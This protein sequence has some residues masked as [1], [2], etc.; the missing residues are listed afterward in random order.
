MKDEREARGQLARTWLPVAGM[1]VLLGILVWLNE[2]LDLPYLLLGMPRTRVNWSEALLETML[3]IAVGSLAMLR[4]IRDITK[5]QRVERALRESEERYRTMI[6]NAN[7][8]IWVL[9]TRGDFTII[10]RQA[11]IVSGQK[12]EDWQGKSFVPLVYPDDLEMVEKVFQKTLAGEPQQYTV[13]VPKGEGELLILS[14]N[15]APVYEKGQ[16]VGTVSFGRDITEQVRAEEALKRRLEQLTALN[17]SSQVMTASLELDQVLNQIVALASAVVEVDYTSVVLVD[18]AGRVSQSTEN[19]PGRPSIMYRIRGEGL[20]SWIICSRQPVIVDEIGA[21]GAIS[22]A[23]GAGAPRFANPHLVEAGVKSIAGLPLMVKDTL[24]GVVFLHSLRPGHFHDQLALLTTFANQA[25]VAVENARLY[26]RERQRVARR[27]HMLKLSHELRLS[28]DLPET[29]NRICQAIV[30]ELGWQQVI[31]SLRDYEAQTSRPVAMAGYDAETVARTLA[32]PPTP[33]DKLDILREEFRF[34]HSYY[35]DHRHRDVIDDYLDDLVATTP[36]LDLEPGGWHQDDILLVPIEGREGILGFIS[37]D[38]PVNRQRP[39]LETV[40]ELETFANQAAVAIENARLYE[41]IRGQA[42]QVQ[43]IMDTVPEGVLLLDADTRILQA[44]PVAREYLTALTDAGVGEVLTDLGSWPIQ[45]LLA[46]PSSGIPGHEITVTGPP[47]RVFEVQAQPLAEAP[48]AGGWVVLIRDATAAREMQRQVQQQ[49]RLAAVGQ[50]A[51]GIAHDFNNILTS[52]IGLAQ[53]AQMVEDVPPAAQA[54]LGHIVQ[55]GQ[56]AAHLIRQV[57]DFSRKSVRTPLLLDLVPFL[58]EVTRFLQRTIPENTRIILE[59]VP[60][61]YW[62]HA[63]PAQIQQALTNL[64]VNA[65]DAMPGGGELRVGLSTLSLQL[66]DQAPLPDLPPGEWVV[67]SVLDTG[68]GI[69]PEVVPHIFEPFFTTKEVGQGTGLGLAQVYGIVKQHDGYIDV[70]SQVGKGTTFTIYLPVAR[71]KEAV[72]PR[73][74]AEEPPAGWGET[75]LLVEDAPI[76]RGVIQTV[77]EQLGYRVLTAANGPEA[78]AVY[79]QHGAEIALV[80]TDLI[81]P[82]MSGVALLHALQAHDPA[83]KVVVTTGYPLGE[84]YRQLEGQG[85][86]GWIQKPPDRARLARVLRRALE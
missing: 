33:L 39:T 46:P 60:G 32:L 53:L 74:L 57:L 38:N 68:T 22:P 84:E 1:F 40:Q 50:L 73:V 21:G 11:E 48:G 78:L 86:A 85:I 76:V 45:V 10:N 55:E 79:E 30:E 42:R 61:D 69:P 80:L 65:R 56:R 24:L 23:L 34:S 2:V 43:R 29:L 14:V 49:E 52:V 20:T 59:V 27:A 5:R 35:I 71:E 3:V 47:R 58:K 77:L 36:P 51:A 81:M 25:A 7:D 82:E 70:A 75:I 17:Q 72:T 67:L 62:V 28:L 12:P 83:V 26:T 31:L 54:D 9:D 44:N 66:G 16:I 64:V 4:L 15:T 41:Q 63:D 37:P 6:E 13:R 18:E 8:M 19:V